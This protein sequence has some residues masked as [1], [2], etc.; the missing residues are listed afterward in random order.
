MQRVTPVILNLLIINVLVFLAQSAFNDGTGIDWITDTFAL[1]HYR[2][3]Y[4]Q[5]HQ[6]ITHMF[7]HGGI[8]HLLFNMFSLWMFGSTI[9]DYLGTQKFLIFYF[10]CG[11]TAGLMQLGFYALNYWELDH[12][13]LS[14]DLKEQYRY[15]LR[16]RVT[17][18][19]SGA[20]MG[21]LV[22]FG[23]LFPN[24][25]IQIM[26]FPIPVKAKWLI[27][28]MVAADLFG[29]F[30]RVPTD[31]VAHFAHLGGAAAGFLL[32]FLWN[33]NRRKTFY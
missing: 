3:E 24:R 11:I 9:E 16:Q 19:A 7:M 33:K 1:H 25:E 4:F 18:G 27:I 15:I 26:P 29:G 22:A 28:I 12:Y 23:Y 32:I 31:N 20:I 13:I 5:P 8:S 6:I 30:A 17:V 2:S 10:I 14:A 21:V